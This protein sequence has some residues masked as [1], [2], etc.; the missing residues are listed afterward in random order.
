MACLL[1][2]VFACKANTP[3]RAH[4]YGS[5]GASPRP[6]SVGSDISISAVS[7]LLP[8][9]PSVLYRLDVFN[10]CFRWCVL[11]LSYGVICFNLLLDLSKSPSF[12]HFLLKISEN[13]QMRVEMESTLLSFTQSAQNEATNVYASEIASFLPCSNLMLM[14]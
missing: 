6:S 1:A 4:S 8:Q 9:D 11:L 5:F 12:N 13:M 10:G 14:L 7:V 3:S 2:V